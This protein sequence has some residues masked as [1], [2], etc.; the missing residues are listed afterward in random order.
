MEI[1]VATVVIFVGAYIQTALGFGLAI[2]AAPIL[3]FLDPL[4]VPAPI[5]I[6]ALTLSLVMAARHWDSISFSG[7]KFAILGR[8][9]GTIAGGMLLV[10]ISIEQ[11]ALWVGISV[12]AAVILSL[13]NLRLKPSA[14]SMF[15]AGFL[16]GFM[17]TSTSIGG[18]PMALL[19][20]HEKSD[21][22]RANMSAFFCA[23]CL[24]S[25]VMLLFVDRLDGRH[26]ALSLPFLPATLAGYWLAMKTVR[27]IS[28]SSL[29]YGSLA[30][31]AIAGSLTVASYWF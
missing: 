11:L 6:S 23:S 3:F 30:L 29:R 14:G 12:V 1:L 24:M 7:L 21:F 9:P 17:G 5:T 2:V 31:C 26:I 15:S 25:L 16:S 13:S 8:I 19:L 4:Y 22:I 10:W 27:K 20:Q 28:H 18:P